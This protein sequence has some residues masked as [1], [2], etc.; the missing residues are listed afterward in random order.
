[1]NKKTVTLIVCAIVALMALGAIFG[2]DPDTAD[3]EPVDDTAT[4]T[5][6]PASLI[7][8]ASITR[9][10][11]APTEPPTTTTAAPTTTS[12]RDAVAEWAAGNGGLLNAIIGSIDQVTVAA[13]NYDISGLERACAGLGDNID[14]ALAAPPIPDGAT[15]GHWQSALN[16]FAMG[17]QLCETGAATASGALIEESTGYIVSASES[18]DKAS[19]A[20][21]DV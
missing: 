3:L 15:N 13:T 6:V 20:L 19:E 16:D 14:R 11:P 5:T 2:G 9:P 10:Q 21:A 18:L 4:T 12:A 8:P 1:M 7:P 17:A